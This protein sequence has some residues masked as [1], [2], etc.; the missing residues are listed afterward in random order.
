MSTDVTTNPA[1]DLIQV[2]QLRPETAES[3]RR[4][5]ESTSP[6]DGMAVCQI[7]HQQNFV[8]GL[9]APRLAP[10]TIAVEPDRVLLGWF[11]SSQ[12]RRACEIR[13]FIL[14]EFESPRVSV[15]REPSLIGEQPCPPSRISSTKRRRFAPS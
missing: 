8:G 6:P 3:L 1:Q 4:L 13:R 9:P 12:I 11:I 7:C 10:V 14:D 15:L 5:F 2:A